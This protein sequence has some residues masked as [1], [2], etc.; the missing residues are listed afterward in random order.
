[1][2]QYMRTQYFLIPLLVALL[3]VS[4]K[5]RSEQIIVSD[6]SMETIKED[7]GFIEP[8]PPPPASLHLSGSLT[9]QECLLQISNNEHPE[10]SDTVF[11][12]GL[13]QIDNQYVV[14]FIDSKRYQQD[15]QDRMRKKTSQYLDKYYPLKNTEFT[16]L[17]WEQVLN[18]IKTELTRFSATKF[19]K[20]SSLAKAGSIT[21][22]CEDGT[23]LQLK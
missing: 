8:P 12:L 14:F 17:S 23:S 1:M 16:D 6:V 15:I 2:S 19:F 21:I 22:Q 10:P 7:S 9:L 18:K 11:H 4:C 13:Y 20:N 5:G 3:A